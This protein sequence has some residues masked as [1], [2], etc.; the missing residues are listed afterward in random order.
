MLCGIGKNFLRCILLLGYSIYVVYAVQF[1]QKFKNQ[2]NHC[3]DSYLLTYLTTYCLVNVGKIADVVSKKKKLHLETVC[4]Y[5]CK[6][7]FYIALEGGYGVWGYSELYNKS[8]EYIKDTDFWDFCYM[9]MILQFSLAGI[10]FLIMT[11]VNTKMY[12]MTT[13]LDSYYN[14]RL[15]Q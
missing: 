2:T 15:T 10:I 13:Q 9:S 5:N 4:G 11:I 14:Q 3:L 6:F 7:L 1:C 8:C 12:F